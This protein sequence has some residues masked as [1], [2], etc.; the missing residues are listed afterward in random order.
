MDA[1]AANLVVR[2]I[3]AVGRSA[4]PLPE[5]ASALV[6]T[7][8]KLFP[9][10]GAYLALLDPAE[11][12]YAPALH[13]SGFDSGTE[14]HLASEFWYAELAGVGHNVYRRALLTR[15]LPRPRMEY[16][17]WAEH[18]EPAG[19]QQCLGVALYSGVE[20]IGM[21][22]LGSGSTEALD[23][24]LRDLLNALSPAMAAAVDPIRSAVALARLVQNASAGAVV[25]RAGAIHPLPGL[26]GHRLLDPG[27]ILARVARHELAGGHRH[28]VFHWP[29]G[30]DD[31]DHL[32]RVTAFA[33]AEAP[34][35]VAAVLVL[36]PAGDLA[37][38][39][40][41]ELE[42]LGQLVAGHADDG[43]AALADLAGRPRAEL[44]D[45]VANLRDKLGATSRTGLALRAARE[46][47][48]IPWHPA[49]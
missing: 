4:A 19:Y 20:R 27:S 26:P 2:D 24:P 10:D 11:R 31:P 6:D 28:A 47:L 7:V 21:L 8:G 13:C 39:T 35:R 42:L 44:R 29:A 25:D 36:A 5:R 46:G 32:L 3:A 9:V 1:K 23:E 43:L 34:A 30:P 15:D 48:Y 49:R 14:A 17:L 16:A 45:A 22:L 38:L 18:L 33:G 12:R 37:A 41:P 40:R